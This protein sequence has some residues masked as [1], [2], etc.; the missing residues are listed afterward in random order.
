LRDSPVSFFFFGRTKEKK[1]I[2]QGS[3]FF[4]FLP[5][6][7]Y[8]SRFDSI[9]EAF[10]PAL[11]LRHPILAEREEFCFTRPCLSV[12]FAVVG[13]LFVPI[14]SAVLLLGRCISALEFFVF[15]LLLLFLQAVCVSRYNKVERCSCVG[16]VFALEQIVL[17]F[18][19]IESVEGE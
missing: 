2:Y 14:D 10:Y 4:F 19:G 3:F 15:V 6:F 16:L 8:F 5:I 17:C 11:Q 13:E 12:G 1:K 18:G 9:P 7:F